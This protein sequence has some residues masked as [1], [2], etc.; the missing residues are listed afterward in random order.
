MSLAPFSKNSDDLGV[1]IFIKE[2]YQESGGKVQL[3]RAKMQINWGKTMNLHS[4]TEGETLK[5][6]SQQKGS[7]G[8]KE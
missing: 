8:R 3:W 6:K 7:K 1:T 4:K 2:N 5:Y